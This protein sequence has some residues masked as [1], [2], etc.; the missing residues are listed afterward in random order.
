M[1]SNDLERR[2]FIAGLTALSTAGVLRAADSGGMI[3]RNLGATGEK[4]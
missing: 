2:E 4:V 3:Y 1:K